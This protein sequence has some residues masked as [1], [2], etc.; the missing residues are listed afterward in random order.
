MT[1]E[2]EEAKT[3]TTT[4]EPVMI[5]PDTDLERPIYNKKAI[6]KSIEVK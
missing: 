1:N 2:E 6:L 5:N 3:K 4:K